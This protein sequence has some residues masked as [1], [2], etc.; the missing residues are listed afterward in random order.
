MVKAEF[1]ESYEPKYSAKTTY[2]NFTDLNQKTDKSINDYTYCIQMSYNSLTDHK[3]ATVAAVRAA[4]PTIQEAKVEGIVDA[5]KF[6]K[7]QLF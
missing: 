2:A 5:F 4:A 3:P 6:V 1:L 7:H